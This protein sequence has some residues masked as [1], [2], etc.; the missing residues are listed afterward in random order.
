MARPGF[1]FRF[2]VL[3]RFGSVESAVLGDWLRLNGVAARQMLGGRFAGA[4]P[5]DDRRWSRTAGVYRADVAAVVAAQLARWDGE[6]LV[7]E[8]Y[9]QAGED[10]Y[11]KQS[12]GG[13]AGAAKT[14]AAR[15]AGSPPPAAADDPSG[16]A[17]RDT[18]PGEPAATVARESRAGDPIGRPDRAVHCSASPTTSTSVEEDA[19][20]GAT[21]PD[22]DEAASSSSGPSITGPREDL[23][24]RHKARLR[25]L[26]AKHGMRP[27]E[28]GVE[29]WFRY[30]KDDVDCRSIDE[31][32][33]FLA[34]I[35]GVA[36]RQGKKLEHTRHLGN[37][38]AEDWQRVHQ[39][40]WRSPPA[41]KAAS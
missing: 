8:G 24:S 16:R 20:A 1:L 2:D 15:A 4:A 12:A 31:A 39:H 5:W 19:R 11:R 10:L 29:E 13:A 18:R 33:A 37:S 17:A 35:A 22:G 32:E 30:L 9:D 21:P 34:W 25:V 40:A 6:D 14:N 26:L 27:N 38:P 3:D 7:L 28:V 36:K 23:A 41:K